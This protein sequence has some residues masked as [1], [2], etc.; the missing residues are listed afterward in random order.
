M[1]EISKTSKLLLDVAHD[2]LAEK[3]HIIEPPF[4]VEI[5]Q[6]EADIQ[7]SRRFTAEIFVKLGKITPDSLEGGIPIDDPYH[8]ISTYFAAYQPGA[9]GERQMVST[10]RLVWSPQTTINDMR[11][12]VDTLRPESAKCLLS[13][14][15]GAVAEIGALVKTKGVSTAA[16]LKMFREMF[17][18]GERNKIHYLVCGLQPKL[19]PSYQQMFGGALE[20]LSDENI[21]FPGVS[22]PQVPLKIDLLYSYGKQKQAMRNKSLGERAVAAV[23]RNYFKSKIP[24]LQ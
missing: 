23:V 9:D 19:Y 21:Y 15:P 18:F 4:N 6:N 11:M 16:T 17:Q 14:P 8:K 7:A 5:L 3:S 12:P 13:Q 22:D 10:A 1:S 24:T 20:K 2:W